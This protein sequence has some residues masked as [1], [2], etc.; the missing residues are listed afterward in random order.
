MARSDEAFV[1]FF[2]ATS[3]RL[4]Y[5]AYLLTGDRHQAECAARMALIRTYAAWPRVR[6]E[7]AYAYVCA[8]LV[9]QVTVKP[10]R[11]LKRVVAKDIPGRLDG[12]DV[13]VAQATAERAIL[14][15]VLARLTF[16]E[17]AIVVLRYFLDVPEAEVARTL[18][19]SLS[20]VASSS[21]QVLT[22]LRAATENGEPVLLPADIVQDSRSRDVLGEDGGHGAAA[23]P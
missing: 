15:K 12:S 2:Q 7:N 6:H 4:M 17:R 3:T 22:T 13:H 14:E 11:R 1:D 18:G 5:A 8:M 10:C 16:R 9:K 21:S 19:V 23:T 20:F